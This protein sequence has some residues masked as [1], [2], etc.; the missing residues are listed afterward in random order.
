MASGVRVWRRR[1]H[2]AVLTPMALIST[3]LER[4]GTD[5]PGGVRLRL[6]PPGTVTLLGLDDLPAS[7]DVSDALERGDMVAAVWSVLSSVQDQI[8]RDTKSPWPQLQGE[9]AL[10]HVEI[11]GSMLKAWYGSND[12]IA[13]DLGEFPLT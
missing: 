10:P 7:V 8:T 13:L 11:R 12:E 2:Q 9:L 5:L 4:L 3:L 6:S 1:L